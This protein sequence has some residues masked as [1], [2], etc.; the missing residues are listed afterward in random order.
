MSEPLEAAMPET[1]L[2]SRPEILLLTPFLRWVLTGQA[3][4]CPGELPRPA[5]TR[6]RELL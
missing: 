3:S 5:L 2:I 4:F 1:S 6:V